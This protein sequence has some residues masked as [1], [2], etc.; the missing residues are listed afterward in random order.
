MTT[1][2]QPLADTEGATY[3]EAKKEVRRNGRRRT[4]RRGDP[5]RQ[6]LIAAAGAIPTWWRMRRV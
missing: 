4:D 5:G 6:A 3:P 2:A 1:T